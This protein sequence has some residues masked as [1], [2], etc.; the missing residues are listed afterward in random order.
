MALIPVET[1]KQTSGISQDSI[2]EPI[3]FNIFIID[4]DNGTE[5]TLSKSADET[6]LRGVADTPGDHKVML[7]SRGNSTGWR[8]GVT[9]TP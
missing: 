6:K 7:P 9:G 2:L 1:R 3:L 5:S 8:N 4:P